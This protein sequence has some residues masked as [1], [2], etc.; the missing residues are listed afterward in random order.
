[1]ERANLKNRFAIFEICSL[2]FSFWRRSRR[3]TTR[4]HVNIITFK[5][6]TAALR[7]GA[8]LFFCCIASFTFGQNTILT[9]ETFFQQVRTQHPL[10][11][12]A[13][14]LSDQ[15]RAALLAARGGFDPKLYGD[16]ERKSFDGKTYFNIGEGGLKLP[17]WFGIEGKLGYNYA[18]GI[19]LDPENKLPSD[20][21]AVLG[22]TMPLLQGMM[23][24]ERRANLFQAKIFR[25][26][27]E[28][29]QR[30]I[31]NDLLLDAAKA[32]WNWALAYA[33]LQTYDQAI[34]VAIVRLDG[35]RES[36]A[37][38]DKPAIDTL[39]ALIQVQD[40]SLE[41]NNAQVEFR[42]AMLELQNFFWENDLPVPFDTTQ[43]PVQLDLQPQSPA[44]LDAAPDELADQHPAVQGYEFK[45]RQLDVERRLKAEQLKPRLDVSY[46]LLGD[47]FDL[48]PGSNGGVADL[49]R[50]NY[51][52]GISAGFPIF[53]RKERGG[54][55]MTNLKILD[56]NYGLS[57][58]RQEIRNKIAAY[59]NDLR[60]LQQQINLAMQMRN[61]YA[62]LLEA[63]N[64]K[65]AIGESSLFL[66]NSREN[67]LIEADLKLAKL[68]AE[69]MKAEAGLRWAAGRL[70]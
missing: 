31:R 48:L 29:E 68:Q 36:Y 16:L 39:E 64:I 5:K 19:F 54:L 34:R 9:P 30:N 11:R 60:N 24:D 61:N 1:M 18:S 20:G 56:A 55:Q 65:F 7:S 40:R 52:F 41:R 45:L 62:N 3:I 28:A 44:L 66:V 42:N 21:Q 53:L 23:M 69:W 26:A 15:A 27:N 70:E 58:K 32:Y 25:Q 35:L 17:T 43:R 51:K 4:I 22:F 49:F 59:Q 67:K 63:E 2:L 13:T 46:N 57:R 38:G 50:D 14:L 37:V 10:A 8:L 6:I 47:G 33:W 12:Q